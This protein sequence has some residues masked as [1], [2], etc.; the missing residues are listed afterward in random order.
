M[1]IY[2]D[3]SSP[4]GQLYL[5]SNGDSLIGCYFADSWNGSARDLKRGEDSV[6]VKAV[7]QLNEYFS[8][9]RRHFDLNLEFSGTEFQKIVW[10]SLLDIPYGSTWTY[11]QQ[12]QSIGKEKAV[13]AVGSTNG[14]NPLSIFVPCHRVI[15]SSG[16]LTGYAGGL[17][18]KEFLLNLENK[19]ILD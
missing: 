9:A 19:L 6:L 15:G 13:R 12:A 5:L 1:T 8:G 4:I 10:S 7:S 17:D 18:K 3:Y 14:K 2:M 11:K 16:K